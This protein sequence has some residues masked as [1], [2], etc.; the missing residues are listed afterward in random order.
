MIGPAVMPDDFRDNLYNTLTARSTQP[1][2]NESPPS[3]VIGPS[4]RIFLTLNTY[5]L[6]ENKI[7]PANNSQPATGI[8]SASGY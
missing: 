2:M 5:K 6:P 4:Q 1:M 3:G 7:R 8:S